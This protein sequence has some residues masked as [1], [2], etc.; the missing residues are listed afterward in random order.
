LNFQAEKIKHLRRSSVFI[1]AKGAKG[2][3]GISVFTGGA[4]G[5]TGG[6]MLG[7]G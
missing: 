6:S 1:G 4:V 2:A 7:T 5:I 3:E